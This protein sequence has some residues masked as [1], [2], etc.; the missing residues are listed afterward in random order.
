MPVLA[1][2]WVM[3]RAHPYCCYSFTELKGV[4]FF[5]CLQ[6]LNELKR[7]FVQNAAVLSEMLTTA[8]GAGS[9]RI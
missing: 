7:I 5:N 1:D 9:S 8:G 3:V 6:V 2:C 4:K